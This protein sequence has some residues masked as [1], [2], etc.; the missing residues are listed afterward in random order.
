MSRHLRRS[1]E[2]ASIAPAEV[3]SITSTPAD[4][5]Y[6]SGS[7]GGYYGG[8]YGSY[9]YNGGYGYGGYGGYGDTPLVTLEPTSHSALVIPADESSMSPDGSRPVPRNLISSATSSDPFSSI[10]SPTCPPCPACGSDSS[11]ATTSA[12]LFLRHRGVAASGACYCRYDSSTGSWALREP[13]CRA[14]LYNK[15]GSRGSLLECASLEAFY[16]GSSAVSTSESSKN[17][18]EDAIA[19]FLFV[20]CPPSPPCSCA[21]LRLDGADA[22]RAKAQCCSDLRAHCAAPFSG[23]DCEEVDAYCAGGAGA[24]APG[25]VRQFVAVKTHGEDCGAPQNARAYT[26]LVSEGP[27]AG[28]QLLQRVTEARAGMAGGVVALLVVV[29][30]VAVGTAVFGMVALIQNA[31]ARQYEGAPLLY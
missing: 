5:T 21:V 6:G 15:C 30:A 28:Q 4:S 25:A 22:P 13:S 17:T 10:Y 7:S 20:D 8:G 31:M 14:A 24:A 29:A 12:S 16:L 26:R 3:P 11:S 9:G 2:E 23:L 1:E 18:H 27:E 19:A